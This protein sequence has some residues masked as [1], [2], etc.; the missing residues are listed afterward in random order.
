MEVPNN[1]Y[2]RLMEET[3]AKPLIIFGSGKYFEDFLSHYPAL[4]ET[5]KCSMRCKDCNNLMWAFSK[6]E[7]WGVW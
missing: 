6:N 3:L 7:I 4:S 1:T 2:E 5:P